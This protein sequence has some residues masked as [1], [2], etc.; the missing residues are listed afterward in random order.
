MCRTVAI[1]AFDAAKSR[2]VATSGP[3]GSKSR[4]V[5]IFG[6]DGSKSRTVAT[7]VLDGSK[8]TTVAISGPGGSKCRTVAIS[9]SPA[10]FPWQGGFNCGFVSL[11]VNSLL[12]TQLQGGPS[13]AAS[14]PA[15]PLPLVA[16]SEV[17]V[18]NIK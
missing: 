1:S 6:P 14:G 7:F 4:T 9:T 3:D 12:R 15:G 10:D 8:C 2:T 16:P 17:V 5:A 11:V 18:N 13:S